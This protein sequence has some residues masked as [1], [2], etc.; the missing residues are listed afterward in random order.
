MR[1]SVEQRRLAEDNLAL[2][3]KVIKD[4]VRGA[5]SIGVFSYEDLYQFGCV[6]LCKAACTDKYQYA[7]NRENAH[8]DDEMRF[9][10][11][12]Y[13]LIWH[14]ICKQ[15]EYATKL[16]AEFAANPN[17]LAGH[18]MRASAGT[19]DDIAAAE[20]H[21]TL[22]R[23]VSQAEK[24]ASATV[25]NG[26]RALR[27]MAEGYT[28]AEIARMMG[29]ASCHNVTAWV[30]KARKVLKANPELIKLRYPA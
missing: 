30:S 5:G 27:Y 1:L 8:S 14:E 29:A 13:R 21:M 16:R 10:T 26:I 9:S 18:T 24:G 12:A 6:G 23:I 20:F 3:R 17:E 19:G 7:Y 22:E 28:S 15:L 11:Y 2:V 25:A 4:K